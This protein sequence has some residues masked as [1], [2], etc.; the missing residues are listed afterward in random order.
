MQVVAHRDAVDWG[1]DDVVMPPGA[2]DWL[3]IHWDNAPRPDLTWW[4]KDGDLLATMTLVGLLD[5]DDELPGVW[6]VHLT[7]PGPVL[8]D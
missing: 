7:G 8:W 1:R 5:P 2:D 6:A 4:P 3:P